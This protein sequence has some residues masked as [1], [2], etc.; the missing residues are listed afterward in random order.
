MTEW[1]LQLEFI[2]CRVKRERKGRHEEGKHGVSRVGK[3]GKEE[4]WRLG[5]R[6]KV[7]KCRGREKTEKIRLE[8]KVK[9]EREGDRGREN[10]VCRGKYGKKDE[11]RD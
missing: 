1:L 7:E 6:G 9:Y 2:K 10:G 3:E 5:N 8:H 11:Y 4:L